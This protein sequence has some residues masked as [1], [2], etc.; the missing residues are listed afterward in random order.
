MKAFESIKQITIDDRD[1]GL[2]PFGVYVDAV[3][4]DGIVTLCRCESRIVAEAIRRA[5]DHAKGWNVEPNAP[6]FTED[7]VRACLQNFSE[8]VWLSL[9]DTNQPWGQDGT[10]HSLEEMKRY[11][12]ES[13]VL[14]S[15]IRA[16]G[17]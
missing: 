7:D 12:L 4:D 9:K 5:I 16:K 17:R 13:T 8:I 3:T 6:Q 10:E 15:K 14:P 1:Y 2:A 11:A